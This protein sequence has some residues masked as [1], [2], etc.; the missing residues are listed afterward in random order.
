MDENLQA[1]KHAEG[2][3]PPQRGAHWVRILNKAKVDAFISGASWKEGVQADRILQLEESLTN[4]VKAVEVMQEQ[5]DRIEDPSE[6]E[7]MVADAMMSTEV[8][9]AK[10]LLEP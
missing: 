7:F 2:I 1:R 8:E 6:E 3:Y 9:K 10:I 4:L 5:A